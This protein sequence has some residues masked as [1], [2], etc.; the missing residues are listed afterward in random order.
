VLGVVAAACYFAR[1]NVLIPL[2]LGGLVV[3]V[4]ENRARIRGTAA[5]LPILPTATA[6]SAARVRPGTVEVLTE[7]AK[8]GVVVFGSGYVLLAFLRADLVSH[9]HWLTEREVLDAVAAGQV[10]PGPVFTTATFV[11][12]LLG[13]T[14]MALVATA[15][16]FVPS[17]FMVAAIEPL[18]GRIRRSQWLAPALDGITVA[19]LGLM[20]GV[21]VDLGRTAITDPLTFVLAGTALIVLLRWRPNA[22]WLVAAGSAVGIAHHLIT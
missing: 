22:V 7:F 3:A 2:L 14:A 13:G 1:L 5:L 16:I 10:T 8:L 6:T 17:F 21:T 19:A 9:L 12:Y 15:G 11:G 20:A 18:V 4:V